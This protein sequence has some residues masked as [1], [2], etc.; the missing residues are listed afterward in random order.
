MPTCAVPTCA[1]PKEFFPLLAEN[2]VIDKVFRPSS[3][4][5]MEI[6]EGME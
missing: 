2:G 6:L 1:V 3:A 4:E 5:E